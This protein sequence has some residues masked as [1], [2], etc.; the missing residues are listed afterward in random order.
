MK[1]PARGG[2]AA[3]L[4]EMAEKS[5]VGIKIFEERIPIKD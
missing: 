1:G 5:K 4:N 2:I 3:A